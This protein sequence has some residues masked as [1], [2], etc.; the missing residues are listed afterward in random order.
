VNWLSAFSSSI[1]LLFVYLVTVKVTRKVLPVDENPA[2]RRV[3]YLAGVVGALIAGFATTFWDNAIE[4]EV[5][6]SSC[7]I[8][9][10]VVWLVLRWEERLDEGT[11]DGFLLVITYL[12]GLGVGIHLGV[13]L[14][15]WAAVVFVFLARPRYLTRWNYLGWAIV[16]LSL[17]TGPE[18]GG[19]L[20]QG[21]FVPAF[22]IAPAILVLTLGIWVA[23]GRFHNLAFWGALLFMAGVSVHFYLIIRANLDPI[24]NEAAPKDWTA[25]WK[26]LIRDQYKPKI[27]L[28]E[29]SRKA[30]YW[31]Q[32]DYMWFRY[33]W[34]N[35]SLKGERIADSYST[36]QFFRGLFQP[37]ILL[38][39]VGMVVH[40]LRERR[41]AILLGLL[42][43][44]LGPVMVVYLNFKE[45]EVR[46]RDYFFVQNFMFMS[47]WVGLGAAWLTNW[48]RRQIPN[49]SL[50]RAAVV[51]SGAALLVMA[52]IPLVKNWE[53]H[54]RRGFMVA[55]NY[56]Y[57]ML[58]ALEPNAILF[59]N[60]DNDTFPLWY[61]QEVEGVRKDV[62]VVNLSLL[63]TDWYIRQLRDLEPTVPMTF[64]D[65]QLENTLLWVVRN[66]QGRIQLNGD[67][68]LGALWE[69]H[70]G[71]Y[72]K[73]IAVYNI[74]NQNKWE[75]PVY[76]AVTVPD[77]M[78]L[79]DRLTMEG[80]VFRVYQDPVTTRMD[81]EK[82]MENL[83]HVYRYAGLI[84]E[85]ENGNRVPDTRVHKDANSAKLVQNYAA[86]YARLALALF[87][88]DQPEEALLQIEKAELIAPRFPG[89]VVAKG[90]ILERL[91]RVDEAIVHYAEML[92]Y[93]PGDWQLNYRLGE[94]LTQVGR[95]EESID[96]FNR[97]IDVAPPNQFYPY[98]GLASAYY[99]LN[100]YERA[101]NVLERWLVLHPDDPNV[102]ELYDELRNSVRSGVSP[103][104]ADTGASEPP[105][106]EVPDDN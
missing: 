50:R 95:I 67:F 13:A 34:W 69:N 76:L 104:S 40:F 6:A 43:V 39:I 23:T 53:T 63:N 29:A 62:R 51:V 52:V 101:A 30:P 98:Q 37:T 105:A 48:V 22:V 2:H 18:L 54:D 106:V 103:G 4:A 36:V 75:R 83:N 38:A 88:Q 58:I 44:L 73:D 94:A 46:E 97:A 81:R 71:W 96:Y 89:L 14:A 32:F 56:A 70:T 80:L 45:G 35:F 68:Q 41:T 87:E 91:D 8:M 47:I 16:T 7:A 79:N 55:N 92:R 84:R 31:Y 49:A 99:R 59:T 26:M 102:R 86:A 65:Q 100:M 42:F 19:G 20:I 85:D 12:V 90:V 28:D 33:M 24:I 64:T 11:E 21:F 78:G 25:L 17:A 15:A 82:T 57:N 66:S 72:V 3:S 93:Y 9:V 61:L 5:Y 1:A 27:G 77:Q 60:G 10:L 74:L